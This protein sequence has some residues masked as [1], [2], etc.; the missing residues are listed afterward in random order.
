MFCPNCGKPEQK[1]NSYCRNCGIFLPDFDNLKKETTPEQHFIVNS[2]LNGL[3]IIVSLALAVT[4]YATFLGKEGTP[5]VI[6]LT[7]GFLTAIF[8][9]Q[10]QIFIRNLKLKKHFVRSKRA[11][12]DDD[13][14]QDEVR[15]NASETGKLLNEP[16]LRDTV[17][18]SVTEYTTKNLDK[19]PKN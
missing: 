15:L 5:M 1:E 8:F 7:A 4:L 13:F 17:P 11:E 9:W 10:V 3:T 14:K 6:Y 18:A 19:I 2:T 12:A 16:D